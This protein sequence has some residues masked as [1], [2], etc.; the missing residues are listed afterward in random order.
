MDKLFVIGFN[1]TGTESMKHFLIS[2]GRKFANQRYGEVL[3][4]SILKDE[5][6]KLHR[7]IS[8]ADSFKDIPY[9]IN[10]VFIELDKSYPDSKFILT[11]R[12]S[13]SWFKS[14]KHF[15]KKFGVNI[16]ESIKNVKYVSND[17]FYLYYTECLNFDFN[18]SY[19]D[20]KFNMI[21]A[22]ESYNQRV[23]DYFKDKPDKLL[24][25]D[26]FDTNKSE[27]VCDFLGIKYKN[28]QYP[29]SNKTI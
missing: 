18:L 2:L 10:N 12:D 3:F 8:T 7:L 16:S 25:I 5:Y 20:N 26:L 15:H 14:I 23:K 4:Q 11:T 29:H 1:K 22:Y 21:N 27:K 6:E 28:Q 17:F 9:N 24:V 13:E 19:D